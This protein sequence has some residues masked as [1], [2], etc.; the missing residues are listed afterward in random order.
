V[1]FLGAQ[2]EVEVPE[3]ADMREPL[4]AIFSAGGRINAI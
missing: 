3:R 1:I 2:G 4:M